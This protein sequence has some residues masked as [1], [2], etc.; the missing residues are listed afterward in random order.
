[1]TRAA[2]MAVCEKGCLNNL[3]SLAHSLSHALAVGGH[4]RVPTGHTPH[5]TTPYPV[6]RTQRS[7]DARGLEA[8]H[9]RPT[10]DLSP[11]FPAP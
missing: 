6:I 7:L 4:T 1:M 9:A 10:S 2:A 8:L 11:W 3:F 5:D